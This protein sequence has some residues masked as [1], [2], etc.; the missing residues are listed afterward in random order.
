MT[1][2]PVGFSHELH[3][4]S[5]DIHSLLAAYQTMDSSFCTLATSQLEKAK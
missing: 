1:D 2:R 4:S 5:I 3:L